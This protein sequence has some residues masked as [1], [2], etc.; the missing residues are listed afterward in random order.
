MFGPGGKIEYWQENGGEATIFE[1]TVHILTYN[2]IIEA[3]TGATSGAGGGL[4]CYTR[5]Y[6]KDT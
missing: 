4:N 2:S 6:F 1:Y 5:M 3:E